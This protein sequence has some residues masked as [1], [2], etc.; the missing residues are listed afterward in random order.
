MES[1]GCDIA[2]TEDLAVLQEEC[3]GQIDKMTPD[4]IVA[5][6]RRA[7]RKLAMHVGVGLE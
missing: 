6:D 7:L 5:F 4:G 1:N 3:T 2:N